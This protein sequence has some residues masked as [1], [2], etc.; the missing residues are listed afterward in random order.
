MRRT[1]VTLLLMAPLLLGLPLLGAW[2]DG[3][4][5]RQYLEFPPLTRYVEHAAFSWVGFTVFGLIAAACLWGLSWGWRYG[6][7]HAAAAGTA[8]AAGP[9][10]FP[11]WGWAGLA[12]GLVAWVLAWP[13]SACGPACSLPCSGS[14]LF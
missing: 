2:L 8:S 5:L 11:W 14:R 6:R 10:V 4:D 7:R 1:L 9:G 3:H 13:P 12:L